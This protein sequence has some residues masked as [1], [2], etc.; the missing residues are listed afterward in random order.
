M[1]RWSEDALAVVCESWHAGNG[2]RLWVAPAAARP[3]TPA[4]T[5]ALTH[6]APPSHPSSREGSRAPGIRQGRPRPRCRGQSPS[7][8]PLSPAAWLHLD[9][10]TRAESRPRR[11]VQLSLEPR[12][13]TTAICVFLMKQKLR[14]NT[15][16][17]AMCFIENINTVKTC[18]F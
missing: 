1:Q 9:T 11:L 8:E 14:R 7:Q 10:E 18:N 16:F 17:L 15:N 4:E 2:G 3:G 12:N 13:V 5:H 6:P